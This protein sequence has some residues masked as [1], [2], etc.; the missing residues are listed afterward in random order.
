MWGIE[1]RHQIAP[2][3]VVKVVHELRIA[4]AKAEDHP[5]IGLYR[6][7]GSPLIMAIRPGCASPN[8]MRRSQLCRRSC[9]GSSC[10]WRAEFSAV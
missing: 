8:A 10:G 5:P 4:I 7:C 9:S 3:V 1:L 2:L 6:D